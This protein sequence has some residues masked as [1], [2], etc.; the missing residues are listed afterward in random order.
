MSYVE[1]DRR[2]RMSGGGRKREKKGES[3]KGGGKGT[4]MDLIYLLVK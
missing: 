4:L 1:R 3:E 2:E